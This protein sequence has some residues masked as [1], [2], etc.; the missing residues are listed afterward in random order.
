VAGL[1]PGP[2]P[3]GLKGAA[4]AAALPSA[5]VVVEPATPPVPATP[6]P[7][8]GEAPTGSPAELPAT[9]LYRVGAGDVLDVRLLD[10]NPT[11]NTLYAVLADGSIDYPLAG[12]AVSVSGRTTEEIAT[13]LSDELKRRGVQENPRVTVGVREYTSHT[14]IVSGLVGEPGAKT[15]RREALPLYVVLADAQPKPEAGRALVTSYATGQRTEVSLDDQATLNT[16]VRP[17]DVVE[18]LPKRQ[19]FYYIGGKVESPG[20]KEFRQGLTLTQAILASGGLLNSSKTVLVT[21][22]NAEG[23]LSTTT[24]A[25]PEIMSG[26]APDPPLQPGDRVEVIR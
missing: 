4:A 22:Q 3:T 10:G 9:S 16:L 18:V 8:A 11:A 15:L 14:V 5:V 6:P 2:E 7:V 25:L 24:Y 1:H 19:Q 17:G 20:E 21:R 13:H 12:S 26:K 23:L